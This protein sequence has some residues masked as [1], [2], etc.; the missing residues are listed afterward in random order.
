MFRSNLV[1]DLYADNVPAYF[2]TSRDA[3]LKWDGTNLVLL[4]L[5]DDTGAFH[6]GNGTLD[7]DVKVF[8]N[9]TTKYVLFDVGGSLLTLEDVD[10]HLGDNDRAEFGDATGGDVS[11]T[12][13]GSALNIL[14]A[15][16]DTGAI[17]FGD[18]TTD[19]DVKIFMGDTLNYFL[20]DVG[21]KLVKIL[22]TQAG[23]DS[24]K[25]LLVDVDVLTGTSGYRQG[26]IQI[27]ID[28]AL[29]QEF[30]TGW[31]GNP[32]CGM[33]ILANNRANNLDG[34]AEIGGIRA[35]DAQAR[36][37]G[38]NLAWVKAFEFN[39]RN[40]SGC[41][42]DDLSVLHLRAENY[43]TVNDAIVALDVEMSS[44]NDT[45]SPTKTAILVRNTDLSG[46]T[47]VDT[48]LK[49]SHTS[50]N[51]FTYFV[52]FSGTSGESASTGTLT[53][54]AAGDVL[55]DARIACAFNGT[56]YWIPLFNTAP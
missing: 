25:G 15:T 39:G 31:D 47:A 3:S 29:G 18:G 35:L 12:W 55:C 40:D 14:P 34:A 28:R 51:G 4:P 38:T 6:I 42:V 2:G 13:N 43:G 5:V 21:A 33:K 26:A 17:N 56:N 23:G 20:T 46:M 41:T 24:P 45:S 30:T 48:I 53:D 11:A 16:D 22:N 8:L 44:E 27:T 36:N 1:I 50:T 9:A 49:V 37:R 32:D 52:N 7:F 19:M 10:L 54:S